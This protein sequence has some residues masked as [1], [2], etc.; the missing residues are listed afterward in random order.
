MSEIVGVDGEV[1]AVDI[2]PDVVTAASTY[3]TEAGYTAR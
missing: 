1:T 2:D 3:L